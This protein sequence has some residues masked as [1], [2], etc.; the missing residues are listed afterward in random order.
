MKLLLAIFSFFL[1][2]ILYGVSRMVLRPLIR[3]R[4]Y[5]KQGISCDFFPLLGGYKHCITAFKKHGDA[6]HHIKIK[7]QTEPERI[8]CSNLGPE[9]IVTPYDTALMKD[10]FL[11]SDNY[12]KDPIFLELY[13]PL[14]GRG[15]LT[16]E[17]AKWKAQRKILSNAFHFGFLKSILP[18]VQNTAR[19]TFQELQGISLNK[20]NVMDV[21]QKITGEVVGKIFFGEQL[22][23]YKID[24][25][26]LTLVLADIMTTIGTLNLS[27]ERPLLGTW[28]IQQGIL[29]KHKK[30]MNRIY[31]FKSVCRSI[32]T[33]RKKIRAVNKV[34]QASKDM[35]DLLL[36]YNGEEGKIEEEEIIDQFVTFFMAGM[37]TTGH[38]VTMAVYFLDKYPEMKARV[39]EEV[40]T[41]YKP[42]EKVDVD[43][44]NKLEFTTA[45]L[46]ETLRMVSPVPGILPRK[47][48]KDHKLGEFHIKKGDCVGLDFFY[49]CFNEQYFKDG[50]KFNPTRFLEKEK[51]FD[52]YAF[53]PFSAGARNCI[54]QH[55]ALNESRIILAELLTTY[56]F[57]LQKDYNMKLVFSFLYEPEKPI[58]A[59]LEIKQNISL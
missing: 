47:A 2:F 27:A 20:V 39:I 3:M 34:E 45:F 48:I 42:Q 46:R 16:S 1:A 31:N 24:N 11:N 19:E 58:L 22:N 37:D 23:Q 53:V 28:F 13:S 17:G 41:H 36:E 26:P 55:L 7:A 38:L 29:P 10:F 14:L 51:N 21:F 35:L 59:D 32:I 15:L 18:T 8:K 6:K 52:A 5:R 30:I 12:I 57:T 43:D 50:Q 56:D 4:Y 33:E 9:V 54:G 49:N 44:L 25:Q 40:K